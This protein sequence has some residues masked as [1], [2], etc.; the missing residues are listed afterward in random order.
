MKQQYWAIGG[1]VLVGQLPLLLLH[2]ITRSLARSACQLHH[3][4]GQ[5][6]RNFSRRSDVRRQFSSATPSS[7]RLNIFGKFN[8]HLFSSL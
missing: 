1:V 5:D 3:L 4:I 7:S 6:H 8:S 2:L